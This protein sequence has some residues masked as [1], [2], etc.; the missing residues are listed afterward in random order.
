[1]ISSIPCQ[2]SVSFC[3]S[4][5][6]REDRLLIANL[7]RSRLISSYKD[8]PADAFPVRHATTKDIYD[9]E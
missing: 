5:G 6:V 3:F 7:L 1:V 8:P 9:H 4:E 2:I